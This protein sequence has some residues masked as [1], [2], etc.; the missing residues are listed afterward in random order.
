MSGMGRQKSPLGDGLPTWISK[1][2]IHLSEG[3]SSGGWPA[4]RSGG[5]VRS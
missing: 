3:M 2:W 1:V 5:F 4:A